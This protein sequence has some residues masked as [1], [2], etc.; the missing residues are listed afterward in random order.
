MRPDGHAVLVTLSEPWEL[1]ADAATNT[2]R[3]SVAASQGSVEGP[4]QEVMAVRLERPLEWQNRSHPWLI[5]TPRHGHGLFEGLP[6][7]TD[8]ECN[9]Y[10]VADG[11]HPRLNNLAEL[12]AS[13][14]GGL[15]GIASVRLDR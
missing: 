10:A 5:L 2:F 9:F 3:G 1:T 12:V 4:E 15:A 11:S 13:W 7:S 6:N 8:L 14:R